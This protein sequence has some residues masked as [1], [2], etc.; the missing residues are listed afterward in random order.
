MWQ[1]EG[2]AVYEESVITGEGRLHAGDFQQIVREAARAHALEPLDRVNGGLTDWPGG[3]SWYAYGA[4][5]HAYLAERFGAEKL[6]VLAETTSRSL[7]YA[8]SRAFKR[9]ISDEKFEEATEIARAQVKSGAHVIDINLENT[10]RDELTDIDRFYEKV[11]HKV[12]VPFMID[13]TNAKAIERALTYCLG[14]SII[15]SINFED[16][17]EKFHNILPLVKRYGAGSPWVSCQRLSG[18]PV[19]WMTSQARTWRWRSPG[20]SRATIAGSRSASR[21][22]KASAPIASHSPLALSRKSAG[23]A[24]IAEMPCISA[25]K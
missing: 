9:L 14:K 3:F 8:G 6:A 23:I 19:A 4:G 15:N 10:D 25:R 16:G 17:E 1:I 18:R 24:G 7:L 22:R 12:K 20:F 5:F 11:I 2:L 13:T 21:A